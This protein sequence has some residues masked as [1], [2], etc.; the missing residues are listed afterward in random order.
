[1]SKNF[2]TVYFK[3]STLKFIVYIIINCVY[4]YIVYSPGEFDR[5]QY[6]IKNYHTNYEYKNRT[7]LVNITT[8]QKSRQRERKL[9]KYRKKS[10]QYFIAILNA[11]EIFNDFNTSTCKEKIILRCLLELSLDRRI[12]KHISD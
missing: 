11:F 9:K 12:N 7:M 6:A 5:Q 4:F 1:M 10:G 8:S 3:I 2:K